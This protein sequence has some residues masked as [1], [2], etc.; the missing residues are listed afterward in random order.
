M[1]DRSYDAVIIGGGHHATILAPY[2]AKAGMSIGVFEKNDRLGGGCVTEDGPT[3]GFR[4]AFCAQYTRFY[5]HPAFRDFNLYDEGLRYV[6]PETGAGIV[7]DDGSSIVTYPAWVLK[8]PRTGESEFV[9]K[10]VKKTY[11]Q[12][13][14]VSKADAETYI[15]LTEKFKEKWGRT[16]SRDRY[17]LLPS[18]GRGALDEL[19]SDPESGL[20]RELQYMTVKQ[21]AHYFFESSEIRMFFYRGMLTSIGCCPD[22]VPGIEGLIGALSVI[23]SWS[24]PSIAIGGSQAVTDALVSAGKK[25]GVEYFVNSGVKKI[26]VRDGK[27]REILLENG[28]EIEA[29]KLV[30]ADIGLL[31]LIN[32]LL[33]EEC[34][35]YVTP[36]VRRRLRAI[37][38]DRNQILTGAVAVHELPNYIASQSNPD[39]NRTFRLYLCPNDLDYIQDKYWH[40]IRL[41][42]YPSRLALL[43][44]AD[45]IWDRTRAPEGK[46]VIWFEEFTVPV[47]FLPYK[48]W[49]TIRERF[50][51][52]HLLPEWEKYAPNMK[53][54][55]VIAS[56]V[57]TPVEDAETHPDMIGG[58]FANS[59]M[60]FS[61]MGWF[62]GIPGWRLRTPIKNLYICSQDMPGGMGIARGSSYRCYLTIAKDLGLAQ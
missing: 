46:H 56:R 45:S 58:C 7:F 12:I 47:R 48:E 9:E 15:E 38:H 59:S 4:M 52:D 33:G 8:D 51:E 20:D 49:R 34:K 57:N 32:N 3:A 18:S 21:L 36:Y 41:M 22:D 30:I 61:Q 39:V 62:R 50:V 54:D 10:N 26:I 2:L 43:T 24:P 6:A 42:G 17:S 5:A 23:F 16:F 14:Q 11:D 13:A 53:K 29:K 60:I 44:T 19:L 25:L 55:N 28:S 35:E 31:Q 40:E 37:D 1:A 27:A